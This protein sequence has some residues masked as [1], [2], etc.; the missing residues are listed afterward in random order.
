MHVPAMTRSDHILACTFCSSVHTIVPRLRQ[1]S[2]FALHLIYRFH[3]TLLHPTSPEGT[4]PD[5]TVSC[6]FDRLSGAFPPPPLPSPAPDSPPT[7]PFPQSLPSVPSGC[8]LCLRLVLVRPHSPASATPR[9][10]LHRHCSFIP[11]PS[12]MNAMLG[13][14]A[15]MVVLSSSAMTMSTWVLSGVP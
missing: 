2:R 7:F 6:A 13:A 15:V 5:P 8:E 4:R 14:S 11:S 9:A 12:P 10:W 3:T 1:Y